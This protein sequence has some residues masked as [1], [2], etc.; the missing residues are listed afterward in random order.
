MQQELDA[1]FLVPPSYDEKNG[2]NYI[3]RENMGVSYLKSSLDNAGF[4]SEIIDAE[5]LNT[6]LEKLCNK[7]KEK[8]TRILA[9]SLIQESI[10]NAKLITDE[11]RSENKDI[12]IVAGGFAPTISPA[13]V[14]KALPAVDYLALGEGEDLIIDIIRRNRENFP[15]EL[16]DAVAYRDKNSSEIKVKKAQ[17]KPNLKTLPHP[18]RAFTFYDEDNCASIVSSRGCFG[19]CTFCC[20]EA[21]EMNVENP[22]YWRARDPEDVV[23]E[24]EDIYK[25]FATKIFKFNDANIFGPGLYGKNHIE[26]LCDE[27]ISRNLTD[28]HFM[29]FCRA[30]AIDDKTASLMKKA[31][32]ER[33]ILG[34]ESANQEILNKF[35]KNENI[36]DV[37]NLLNRL[38]KNKIDVVSG[39]MPFNPYTTINSLKTDLNFLQEQRQYPELT[40]ALKIYDGTQIQFEMEDEGR[41]VYKDPLE[42]YHEYTVENELASLYKSLEALNNEWLVPFKKRLENDFIELKKENTVK[43]RIKYEELSAIIFDVE[44][45][46]LRAL[47]SFQENGFSRNDIRQLL[48]LIRNRLLQIE[49]YTLTNKKIFN[50]TP[51]SGTFSTIHLTEKIF[52]LLK[53]K[54][55]Q[56][57][58]STY[59]N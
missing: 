33:V 2:P 24:I 9:L 35:R 7:I 58:T 44:N 34:I 19:N 16:L 15:V 26:N 25:K 23:D 30:N 10:P 1:L 14:L 29:A 27:L 39:F 32:F 17:K 21:F 45:Y 22:S 37:K 31:G 6:S 47:I 3:P 51:I 20:N 41:L 46:F 8:S 36:E 57:F 11:I 54:E 56:T 55:Y 5:Y 50:K 49:T 53:L 43:N 12:E 13:N 40:N 59:Y 38:K 52:K 18:F 42:G 28:F 4:D 48:N